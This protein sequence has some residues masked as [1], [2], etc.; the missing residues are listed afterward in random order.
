M[1]WAMINCTEGAAVQA[2]EERKHV[3]NDVKCED[4]GWTC[5]P[6]AVESYGNWGK[7]AHDVFNCF[8]ACFW[9]F[10]HKATPPH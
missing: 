1:V 8:F 4:L 2:P 10:K 5:I 7:E 9:T 3:S 6:L